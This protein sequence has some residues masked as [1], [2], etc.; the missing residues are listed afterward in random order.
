MSEKGDKKYQKVM[1]KSK[2][3]VCFLDFLCILFP[4]ANGS[5]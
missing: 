3:H 1:Q 4:K 5:F 2:G